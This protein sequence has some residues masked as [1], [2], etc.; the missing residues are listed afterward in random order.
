[1][2]LKEILFN[3]LLVCERALELLNQ[4]EIREDGTV[5]QYVKMAKL[6]EKS[7]HD[8][9]RDVID[10]AGMMDEYQQWAADRRK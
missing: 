6:L 9:L 10:E 1:M 7:Q 5:D 3:H 4:M 2:N 8:E